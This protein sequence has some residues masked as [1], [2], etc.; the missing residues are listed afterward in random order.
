MTSAPQIRGRRSSKPAISKDRDVTANNL[1]FAVIPGSRCIANRKF[2]N[3]LCETCTPFGW[4][5]D[6]DV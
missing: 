6:P 5:V 3:A 4:P 1:S 2:T